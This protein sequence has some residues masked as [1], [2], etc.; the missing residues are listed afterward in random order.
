[1]ATTTSSSFGP[2]DEIERF[3]YL[4]AMEVPLWIEREES[5]VAEATSSTELDSEP[6]PEAVI[7]TSQTSTTVSSVAND[8]VEERGGDSAIDPERDSRIS[9]SLKDLAP[10]TAQPSIQQTAP[11]NKTSHYLKLVNW[12]VGDNS[13]PNLLV[14][15]RHQTDQPAQS[16]ARTHG[17]S[18]FMQDYIK[19][20]TNFC[21]NKGID[22]QVRL[23]HL[24]EAGL[25]SDCEAIEEVV[26]NLQPVGLLLLGD[27]TVK[28][29]IPPAKDIA[30]LRG[31]LHIPD[32]LVESLVSYHPYTLIK[33]PSLKKL[34]MDDL[35]ALAQFIV[36]KNHSD[37]Q[38]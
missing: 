32:G 4:S 3:S 31:C 19:T 7:S 35:K 30:E 34:A 16:F 38:V 21:T 26:Q 17:P 2:L 33:N 5:V 1:M 20:L 27:E 14:V 15:C 18:Q 13:G 10:E 12:K 6:K 22:L 9:D 8:N 29:L 28:A 23:G 37:I 36:G 25:G 11:S 24:S